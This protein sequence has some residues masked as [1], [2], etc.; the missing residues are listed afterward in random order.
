MLRGYI[1]KFRRVPW[2]KIAKD[3]LRATYQ[4][5]IILNTSGVR[6]RVC[7]LLVF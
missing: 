3:T 4:H 5:E 7:F 6:I 2:G 1:G